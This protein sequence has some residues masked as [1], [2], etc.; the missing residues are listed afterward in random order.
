M[1]EAAGAGPLQVRHEALGARFAEVGGR[2]VPR[3]YGDPAAEYSAARSSAVVV[4]RS[5]RGVVLVHGR[6]PVK[7]IHG[8]ATADVEAVTETRGAYSVLLTPK[9][10]LAAELRIFRRGDVLLLDMDPAAREGALAQFRKYVPPL[11]ARFEDLTDGWAVLGVYGPEAR[12][13]AGAALGVALP[14][15]APEE[16]CV[17][18]EDPAGD[19]VDGASAALAGVVLAARTLYAG[20]DGWELLVPAARAEPL[21]NALAEARATPAGHATLEVLRI[22]AGRPRWG[23]ELTEE[24]IPLEAGLRERAISETK[25]CYTGQE[26]IV[27]ILHRGHVNRALRRLELGEEPAPAAGAELF[28]ADGTKA[29]G[30]VTSSCSSPAAEQTIGLGYVR[31]EVEP[32]DELRLAA[33]DGPPVRVLELP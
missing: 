5:G 19:V 30:T 3:S 13:V 27:R 4:D 10:R 20:V 28:R 26:V 16:G 7:M 18:A 9:G 12:A 29:V 32:P 21:W 14:A 8:L 33:P 15:D 24:V 1:S 2:R 22:E 31:R 11:F 17:W 25:G 23:A 6:D